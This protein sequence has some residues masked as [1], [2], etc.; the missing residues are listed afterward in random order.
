MRKEEGKGYGS[1]LRRKDE[2]GD[3]SRLRKKGEMKK[4]MEA[5]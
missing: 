2:W 4:D 1:R 3:G 5:G